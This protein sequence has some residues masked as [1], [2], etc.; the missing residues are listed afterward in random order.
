MHY[1]FSG[2]ASRLILPRQPAIQLV[3][4]RLFI[5]IVQGGRPSRLNTTR[6]KRFH[7]I[8]H[9]ELNAIEPALDLAGRYAAYGLTFD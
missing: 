6:T 8:A 5:L 2:G 7:E 3:G 9:I 4:K 1:A